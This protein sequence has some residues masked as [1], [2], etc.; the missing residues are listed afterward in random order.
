MNNIDGLL[1]FEPSK[2]KFHPY[3]QV[4]RGFATPVD[5]GIGDFAPQIGIDKTVIDAL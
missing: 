5:P 3:R 1:W 4:V 2:I